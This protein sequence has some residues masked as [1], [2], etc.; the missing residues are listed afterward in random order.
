MS[1]KGCPTGIKKTKSGKC[2]FFREIAVNKSHI[3][4]R[5]YYEATNNN[6]IDSKGKEHLPVYFRTGELDTIRYTKIV[7]PAVARG[8]L[9]VRRRR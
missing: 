5:I 7:S 6:Y 2:K 9:R 1:K 4:G 8:I 3:T